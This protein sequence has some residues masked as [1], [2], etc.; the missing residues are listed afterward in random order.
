MSLDKST[1]GVSK[2]RRNLKGKR[3][4]KI[5]IEKKAKLEEMMK[6]MDLDSSFDKAI[7]LN[8]STQDAQKR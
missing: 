1:L 8:R 7:S 2:L 4:P 3:L 6:D 5:R